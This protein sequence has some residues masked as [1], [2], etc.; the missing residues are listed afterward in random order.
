LDRVKEASKIINKLD[1]KNLL[2]VGCRDCIL[3]SRINQNIQYFGADLFQNDTRSVD[4]VGDINK[5]A[6]TEK[7]DC[8]VAI[9]ILEHVEN[10]FRLF[11]KLL[12]LSNNY[13]IVCLPN[14]YDLK[15]KTNFLIKNSLG[16]KYKFISSNLV[17]RHR[18]LMNYDEI[19]SFYFNKAD[20]NNLLLSFHIV[21]Y[22]E[23]RV[24][25]K[26]IA[27]KFVSIILG[28]QLTTSSIIC[29]F[30]KMKVC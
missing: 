15:S 9:D 12:E 18:W 24:N 7:F 14:T 27:V 29:V 28:K 2:D 16:G 8:V 26:S 5:I 25:L 4:Y 13:L 1:I 6:I 11:D 21:R 17:D 20:D 23:F 10:P 3:K 30:Q 22:G 19:K